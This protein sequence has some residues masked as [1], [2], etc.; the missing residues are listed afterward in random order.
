MLHYSCMS[1]WL[2]H[3]QAVI[4]KLL[5]LIK[6]TISAIWSNSQGVPNLLLLCTEVFYFEVRNV[7]QF[8]TGKD[9]C[10]YT[11]DDDFVMM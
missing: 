9:D 5:G 3:D 11:V 10:H 6:K 7:L 2:S 4:T 8:I 1:N